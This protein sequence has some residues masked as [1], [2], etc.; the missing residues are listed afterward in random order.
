MSHVLVVMRGI[1]SRVGGVDSWRWVDMNS[2]EVLK[3]VV[4][5]VAPILHPRIWFGWLS[6]RVPLK[7]LERKNVCWLLYKRSRISWPWNMLWC[8]SVVAV[9]VDVVRCFET[10][11]VLKLWRALA[12]IIARIG[13]GF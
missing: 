2:L 10:L 3:L 8:V 5:W 12:G 13:T 11:L 9:D 4:I 7:F 6:P 1:E